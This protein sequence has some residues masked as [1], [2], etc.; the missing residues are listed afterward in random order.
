MTELSASAEEMSMVSEELK[1]VNLGLDAG[2]L[3]C[4]T[5]LKTGEIPDL[6]LCLRDHA[7]IKVIS[8]LGLEDRAISVQEVLID[9]GILRPKKKVYYENSKKRFRVFVMEGKM[10]AVEKA[11]EKGSE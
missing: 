6:K 5:I 2:E 3:E 7:P 9:C 8:V 1:D 10:L 11:R 4:I